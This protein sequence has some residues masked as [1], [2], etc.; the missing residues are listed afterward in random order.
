[1]KSFLSIAVTFFLA[2]AISAPAQNSTARILRDDLAKRDG[3]AVILSPEP[4]AARI[5]SPGAAIYDVKE[6]FSADMMGGIE[7][8]VAGSNASELELIA[9]YKG[10]TPFVVPRRALPS[11][12]STV[13]WLLPQ[14][15]QLTSFTLSLRGDEAVKI[16]DAHAADFSSLSLR[17]QLLAA[18]DQPLSVV[19]ATNDKDAN[20]NLR[21]QL[22]VPAGLR[23]S[24]STK[25]VSVKIHGADLDIAKSLSIAPPTP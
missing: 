14:M 7:A 9:I 12:D 3:D 6:K 15:D 10:P 17:E 18:S 25:F 2:L 19:S 13:R 5:I 21:V 8:H 11:Q 4:E 24:L 20:G 1:M 23:S 22:L 16:L